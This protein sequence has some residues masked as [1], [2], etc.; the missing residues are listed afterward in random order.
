MPSIAKQIYSNMSDWKFG[1]T[2]LFPECDV[3]YS[4]V[5]ILKK[6]N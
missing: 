2:F 4:L 3:S 5:G 1:F 6:L